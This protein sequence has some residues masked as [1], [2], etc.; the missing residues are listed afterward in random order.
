M[1]QEPHPVEARRPK[2]AGAV[3]S[4]EVPAVDGR[5][6]AFVPCIA[7]HPVPHARTS[8]LDSRAAPKEHC[9]PFT[10]LSFSSGVAGHT[11]EGVMK[12]VVVRHMGQ[13]RRA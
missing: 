7:S 12:C 1:T 8:R 11:G 2:R 5:K 13:V 6:L 9:A 10:I 3:S 4:V